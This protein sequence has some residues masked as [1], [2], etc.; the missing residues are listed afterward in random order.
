MQDCCT[1]VV[2]ERS[3][4]LFVERKIVVF[5][6]KISILEKS[7]E[8]HGTIC[9]RNKVER[10]QIMVWKHKSV[11]MF[12]IKSRYYRVLGDMRLHEENRDRIERD[13][14]SS[15]DSGHL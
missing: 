11:T 7:H 9:E 4:F 8:G 3:Q 15:Y 10:M 5:L 1:L 14:M 6:Y 2:K 13:I 12:G